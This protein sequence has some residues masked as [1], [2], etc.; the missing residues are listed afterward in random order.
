[1]KNLKQIERIRKVHELIKN[2][3]TGT[4]EHLSQTLQI[5]ERQ[6]YNC[7]EYLKELDAPIHYD[8]KMQTYYYDTPFE[9]LVNV[10]VQ[11]MIQNELR[12]IYAG[13]IPLQKRFTEQLLQV[14]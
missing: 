12:N 4:P 14:F 5:S 13:F 7:I 8:R 9:L 3:K 1:M 2:K 6:V 10:S 11:V